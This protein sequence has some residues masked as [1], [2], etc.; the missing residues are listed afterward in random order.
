MGSDDSA[1][2]LD[3]VGARTEIRVVPFGF[4]M[5]AGLYTKRWLVLENDRTL[6]SFAEFIDAH[7]FANRRRAE[8][9][10]NDE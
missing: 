1:P 2:G 3:F 5:G 8:L 4:P 7:T 6:E 9:Q 10:G